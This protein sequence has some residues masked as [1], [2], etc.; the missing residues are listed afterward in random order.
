MNTYEVFFYHS[1][2]TVI[3]NEHALLSDVCAQSGYP[4]DLVCGGKGTCGKCKVAVKTNGHKETVLACMTKISEDM[5]VYLSAD[6]I[7]SQAKILSEKEESFF[8]NPSIRKIYLSKKDL[9]LEE[10]GS[11]MTP[12]RQSHHLE[13]D[14]ASLRKMA[15]I[16]SDESA[17]GLT[18]IADSNRV[19]DIQTN[20]TSSHLYG[21]AIDIGTTSVVLYAYDMT[22][23]RL[24]GT[25]SSLNG[26][27]A[28]GADVIS[29]IMHCTTQIDG[30]Q[31][32]QSKIFET[33]NTLL[34]RVQAQK[35]EFKEHLYKIILCGNSTMQ[36]LFHGF[37]PEGL[38][39]S[40]FISVCTDTVAS[41]GSDLGLH[42][43]DKCQIV[44]LPLLG[45]FV[46]A[47]TT[48]VLTTVENDNKIKL[49][50]DLGT[51]GEIAVGN[52]HKY[53]VSST[54]CGPALEG[55][56]L[57]FGM[58]GTAGAIET[59]EI[60]DDRINYHVIGD[61]QPKGICG[62]GIVDIVAELLKQGFID[63]TGKMLK[64]DA[65]SLKY[66]NHPFTD[67]ISEYN[68]SIAFIVTTADESANGQ[69]VFVTQKD[70]R[71][72]QLAKGAIKTGCIMLVQ[73]Y[74]VSGDELSEILLAGAFGNYINIK[75]A[76]YIGLIP[77]YEHIPT[78][79]IGNGAGTGVQKYLLDQS[80]AL[81]CD[82][83]TANTTHVE[84]A[85][86]LD[87]QQIYV[88]NMNF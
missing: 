18:L 19:I 86:D 80:E 41:E 29:R 69:P 62:S 24:I 10:Y 57:S 35:P 27:I 58:R 76:Q 33:I 30:L 75:N 51:N 6:Q 42:C 37:H 4:L 43:P 79:S 26:Q 59:F 71:Q 16:M 70:I 82:Q 17:K 23:G 50:I 87:F 28:R 36:H 88:S 77:K 56:G 48:A 81:L 72:I 63:K 5:T 67:R 47:D 78:R 60:L 52:R 65:F 44:F 34:A 20:D 15:E 14:F 39:K 11:Y 68:N 32:L 83:I 46:G 3:V 61:V 12:I 40:P 54:A 9:V 25:F 73:K 64:K 1:N 49:M 53:L 38:G 8:F 85:S 31:D 74:G 66:P 2:R 22:N 7:D 21:A 84:L 45:G 13:P 55:A